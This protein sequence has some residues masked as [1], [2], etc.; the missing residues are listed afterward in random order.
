[1]KYNNW[2]FTSILAI[3]KVIW[4]FKK[5][6]LFCFIQ[7]IYIYKAFYADVVSNKINY[8]C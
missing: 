6:Y 3:F 1:M 4:K 8:I 7:I 2:Y 5:E